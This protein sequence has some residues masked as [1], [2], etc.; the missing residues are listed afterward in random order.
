ME[1]STGI[2]QFNGSNFQNWKFRVQKHLASAGCEKAISTTIAAGNFGAGDAANAA[3]AEFFKLD[4]KAQDIVTSLV[5]DDY[6]EY[7]RDAE[8]AKSMWDSLCAT[9]ERKSCQGQTLIRK[10]LANLKLPDGGDLCAH[11]LKFDSLVRQLKSAGG[12]PSESDLVSQLFVSLPQSFD[13]VVTALENLPDDDLKLTM[14]KSRLL[15]EDAKQKSRNL[16]KSENSVVFAAKK[17]FKNKFNGRCH[18]CN[19]YGHKQKDC[20]SSFG[21]AGAPK[22][23]MSFMADSNDHL[24]KHQAHDEVIFALDSGATD[25]FIKDKWIFKNLC[26]ISSREIFLAKAEQSVVVT[27][28]GQIEAIS[29]TG[30][31]LTINNAL[32]SED[33]RSNLLSVSKIVEAGGNVTFKNN[34]A[35]ISNS[36][37]VVAVGYRRGNL[38]ELK[39]RI[40]KAEANL[41]KSQNGDLWHKRMG[42]IS[43]QRLNDLVNHKMVHGLNSVSP[44]EL[45]DVCIKSKQ[46]RKPFS[47]SR[48]IS[49]RPL[50]R[51]HSDVCGPI[52]PIAWDGSQYFVSFIDDFT[53]FGM[54]Y[55]INRKSQVFENFKNYE[56][57]VTTHF[58]KRIS[59]LTIDQGREYK[60]KEMISFCTDKGIQIL[61]TMAY[62][63]QQNGVAE[64]YNR[65]IMEKVRALLIESNVPKTL[66]TEAVFASVYL[67]N[68][69]PTS[70]LLNWKTPAEMWMN[71]KPNLSKIRV[72]GCQAFVWKPEQ[73]R[74]KLEARSK[75]LVM[76]GYC[77]NGY[78]LWDDVQNKMV[79]SREVIFNENLYTFAEKTEV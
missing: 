15:G 25:H 70:A 58:E 51:V 63:P 55:S 40:P 72:F 14:V 4:K 37:E 52:K 21:T 3:R 59:T 48:P 6:L 35:T 16:E 45:C 54:V 74:S 33:F 62:C 20:R 8:T 57:V 67:I 7:I 13:A 26:K 47:G 73:K 31:P 66:W 28:C 39:V 65:T 18:K 29:N 38:F 22:N 24:S 34:R 10:E 75:S 77:P 11:F 30:A 19:K 27:H 60:S 9:F 23:G 49:K 32:Y 44:S 5:A 42:H 79:T 71:E 43:N 2:T 64:R 78:R 76:M 41:T 69:S 68:R 56:A 53:H 12:N 17:N 46:T 36:N 1:K 50:E 61:E